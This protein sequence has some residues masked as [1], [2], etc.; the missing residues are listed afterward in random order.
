MGVK[1]EAG[2]TPGGFYG[3]IASMCVQCMAAVFAAGAQCAPWLRE[4]CARRTLRLADFIES[5][6]PPGH[7]PGAG[8]NVIGAL[9]GAVQVARMVGAAGAAHIR[10]VCRAML[11]ATYDEGKAGTAR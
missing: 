1:A 8:L 10:Q 3:H 2:S 9:S 11:L 6:F 7:A 5:L 4:A